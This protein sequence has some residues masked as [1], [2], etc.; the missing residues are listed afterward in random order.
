M[1]NNFQKVFWNIF[2]GAIYNEER[3]YY[4]LVINTILIFKVNRLN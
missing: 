1:I 3:V 2:K 4:N